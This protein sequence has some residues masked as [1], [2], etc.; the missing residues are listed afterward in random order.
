VASSIRPKANGGFRAAVF[1]S[2]PVCEFFLADIFFAFL[3]HHNVTGGHS[4]NN[5]P[6]ALYVIDNSIRYLIIWVLWRILDRP[7]FT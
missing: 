2:G 5:P 3:T 6:V 7:R 1:V 4:N